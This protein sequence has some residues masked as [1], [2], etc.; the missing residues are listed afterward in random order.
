MISKP[1]GRRIGRFAF[2]A[3]SLALTPAAA[4]EPAG[5]ETATTALVMPDLGEIAARGRLLPLKLG[6]DALDR[7]NVAGAR[8][9]RDRL[10]TTSID[11]HILAWAIAMDGG[12]DILSSDIAAVALGLP[13]WPGGAKLRRNGERAFYREDPPPARVIAVFGDSQP[14]TLDGVILLARAH[15][16]LGQTRAARE[17][18]SPYWRT[19]K[20]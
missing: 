10:P 4:E 19:Q 11:R 1:L 2:I 17:V 9:M 18:L 14:K 15:A 16:A 8:R 13:D 5:E 12:P 3:A 20:L 6:L 7:G